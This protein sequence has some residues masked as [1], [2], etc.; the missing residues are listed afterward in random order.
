MNSSLSTGELLA[1]CLIAGTLGHFVKL[2]AFIDELRWEL[3][4]AAK[5][6]EDKVWILVGQRERAV[7]DWG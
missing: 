6:W 2:I 7:F 4:E 1:K 3:V 5:F